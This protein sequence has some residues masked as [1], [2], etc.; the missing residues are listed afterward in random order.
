MSGKNEGQTAMISVPGKT[1][2]GGL[3]SKPE[4][5]PSGKHWARISAWFRSF[6]SMHWKR[7]WAVC[8]PIIRA[9]SEPTITGE[10][11][12]SVSYLFITLRILVV[13]LKKAAYP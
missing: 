11:S 12:F 5:V 13:V 7:G 6:S 9:R 10:A 4:V 8:L 2:K 3:G 1:T